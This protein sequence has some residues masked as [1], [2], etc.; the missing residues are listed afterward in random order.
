MR[1]LVFRNLTSPDHKRKILSSS[2]IFDKEGTRTIIRRHFIYIVKEV[3]DKQIEKQPPILAVLKE[4]N[5]KEK[6]EKFFCR[7]KGSVYAVSN[8]RVYL[9]TFMHTLKILLCAIPKEMMKYT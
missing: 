7:M 3:T 6:I 2:E 9:I 1:D 4:R 8:G 5:T